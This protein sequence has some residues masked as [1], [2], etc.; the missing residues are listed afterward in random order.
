MGSPSES[1]R[2]RQAVLYHDSAMNGLRTWMLARTRNLRPSESAFLGPTMDLGTYYNWVG[3]ESHDG[4]KI[5][6]REGVGQKPASLRASQIELAAIG[7]KEIVPDELNRVSTLLY[8]VHTSA[9]PN[10]RFVLKHFP[11]GDERVEFTESQPVHFDKTSPIARFLSAFDP[12]LKGSNPPWGVMLSHASYDLS[13]FPSINQMQLPDVPDF[14]IQA[15]R[16]ANPSLANAST[17]ELFSQVPASMNP[18]VTQY[19]REIKGYQGLMVSDWYYMKSAT[20][21]A[22]KIDFS[23]LTGGTHKPKPDDVKFIMAVTSGMNYMRATLDTS[24]PAGGFWAAFERQSPAAFADFERRLNTLILSTYDKVRS[25]SDPNFSLSDIQDMPFADKV[26]MFS[27]QM[28]PT[29]YKDGPLRTIGLAINETNAVGQ[30]DLWQHGAVLTMQYRKGIV[31]QIT[32]QKFPD[33]PLKPSEELAWFK[34]LMGDQRF[35]SVYD[36]LDWKQLASAVNGNCDDV[37]HLFAE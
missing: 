21:F 1:T 27:N 7:L 37:G 22:E 10:Y 34:Q 32:G 25:S 36:S 5:T 30:N 16:A 20:D 12:V 11:G 13:Q 8:Q 9:H 15:L 18:F 19:L 3:R 31:E 17:Q 6:Q 35:R 2:L 33:A 29:D 26:R 28:I 4:D 24:N 23:F 14:V